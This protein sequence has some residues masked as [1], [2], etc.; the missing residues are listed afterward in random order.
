MLVLQV[1]AAETVRLSEFLEA[2]NQQDISIVFSSALVRSYYNI[3]YNADS[4]ITLDEVN[5]ALAGF[6]LTL[7]PIPGGY[8]V[9]RQQ[10]PVIAP[11]TGTQ[12]KDSVTPLEELIV[13]SSVHE[14][15]LGNIG[16][17]HAFIDRDHLKTRPLVANDPLRVTSR[18]P[19]A[20]T[21]GISAKPAIRGGRSD[22]TLILFDDVRLLE[23][24]HL[25]S[26][27][28]LFSVMDTRTIETISIHTGGF[29][30]NYGD[31]MS[32]VMSIEPIAPGDFEPQRELGLGL[33]TASYL[34]AGNFGP[35]EYIVSARRSTIDLITSAAKSDLG[36]PSFADLYA[37]Y[38]LETSSDTSWQFNLLWYG[39]DVSVNSPDRTEEA[40]S[41]Y[42]NT[43]AWLTLNHRWSDVLNSKTNLTIAGIKNDRTGMVDDQDI[44][45]G[46]LKDDQ[47]FRLFTIDHKMTLRA[48]ERQTWG[49]GG[50]VSYLDAEYDFVSTLEID[51]KF[52]SVSNY[53]RPAIQALQRAEAGI[54]AALFLNSRTSLGAGWFLESGARIDGQDYLKSGWET[55]FS[56]RLGL[57]YQITPNSNLRVSW[58]KYAQAQGIHE[59]DISDGVDEFQEPQDSTHRVISYDYHHPYFEFRLEAYQKRVD[60]PQ[61][62]FENLTEPKSLIPE[63]QADRVR[64]DAD[65]VFAEGFEISI[66][67]ELGQHNLWAGYSRARVEE[68]ENDLDIRRSTDQ[69]HAANLGW[70]MPA[71]Q[72]T[73]SIESTYHSGWPTSALAVAADGNIN[74]SVRNDRR[75]DHF[76]TVDF[77]ASRSWQVGRDRQLRLEAGITNLLNRENPIGNTFEYADG[78]LETRQSNGLP[79]APV[80]DLYLRF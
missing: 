59:L 24:F 35:G 25:N 48:S 6:D 2:A 41:S 47:E 80:L 69:K 34:Q 58:G 28:S 42:G 46:T 33:Y 51:P 26:F 22:E 63:L 14:F 43:Y 20:S 38:F 37:S 18:L 21:N 10:A 76:L 66:N 56:P 75:L 29:A 36:K 61:L 13:T 50:S 16:V 44:V 53:D 8:A 71:G 62:Y 54:K 68:R 39:D 60:K 65:E 11:T 40:D 27:A 57:L 19:G 77:K 52:K 64:V 55:Q 3:T 12:P 70:A 78:V 31:R 73:V 15:T 1:H 67:A 23:P 9:V 30:S 45:S 7:T 49:F 17:S 32:A 5:K 79:I 74:T 4:K 72:W